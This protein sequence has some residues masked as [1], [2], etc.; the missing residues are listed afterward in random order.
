MNERITQLE[1]KVSVLTTSLEFTQKE[2]DDLKSLTKE[3]EEER[4][5]AKLKINTL[6]EEVKE[7]D[8]KIKELEERINYQ[9]DYSRRKNVRISGVPEPDSNETGTDSGFGYFDASRQDAAS[10]TR[11]RTSS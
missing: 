2:V 8:D 4:K 11:V 5:G 1:G 7:K 3:Q 9:D 6:I 10:W